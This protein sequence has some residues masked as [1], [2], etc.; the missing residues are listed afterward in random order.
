MTF[1]VA[2]VFT[3]MASAAWTASAVLSIRSVM[4]TPM[5]FDAPGSSENAIVIT[6]ALSIVT[7]PVVCALA[8][9]VSWAALYIR[10]EALAIAGTLLPLANIVVAIGIVLCG[11]F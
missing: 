3:L 6:L 9:A 1:T 2:K 7:F 8:I 4:M 10:S 5:L 11:V